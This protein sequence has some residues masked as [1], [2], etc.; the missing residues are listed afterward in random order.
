MK[1]IKHCEDMSELQRNLKDDIKSNATVWI[2]ID[3]SLQ[4][5]LGGLLVTSPFIYK[6]F[7]I[8]AYGVNSHC[9]VRNGMYN[10]SQCGS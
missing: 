2:G 10:V 4:V 3:L 9:F 7:Y 6:R 8:L 1:E 5:A